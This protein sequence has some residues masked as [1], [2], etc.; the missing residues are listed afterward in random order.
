MVQ[1]QL[2]VKSVFLNVGANILVIET[3]IE[4]IFGQTTTKGNQKVVGDAAIRPAPE[5]SSI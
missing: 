3:I 4:T 1:V 2:S 5:S